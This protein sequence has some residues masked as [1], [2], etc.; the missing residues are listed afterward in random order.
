MWQQRSRI[1]WLKGL[2]R[3][4]SFFMVRLP[5]GREEILLRDYGMGMGCGRR[6][7]R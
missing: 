7:R 1:Q 6:I 4:L 3:I 5:K 2:I